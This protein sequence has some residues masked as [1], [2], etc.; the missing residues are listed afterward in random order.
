M[1]I[2]SKMLAGGAVTVA[3]GLGVRAVIRSRRR[4][5]LAGKVVLITG[6]SR[7]LGLALARRLVTA[8]ASVAICARDEAELRR[9][10]EDLASRGGG[11]VLSVVCDIMQP[12]QVRQTVARVREG[13]GPVDVLINNAGDITVGPFELQDQEDFHTAF[14]T[15]VAAPLDFIRALLPEMRERRQGRIVNIASIGGKVP[16]PHLASYVA[17]KYAL[18]GLTET[19]RAELASRNILVTLVCPGLMRTGS[20]W[21]AKFKGDPEAEYAWFAALDN[22]RG[23]AINPDR[24]AG[25]II[26]AMQHGDAELITPWNA[27]LASTFHGLFSGT[28]MELMTLQN[29]LLPQGGARRPV[30][31]RAADVGQLPG[32]RAREQAKNASRFNEG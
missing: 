5:D 1:R 12:A 26:D 19:I 10:H 29:A 2:F 3:A 32:P 17:S 31:G 25:R 4:I 8:G 14:A 13:L 28:F 20:P 30:S 6:G 11:R 21:H 7:G 22:T 18:V 27:K 16:V 23:L 9:A 24:M 15:H